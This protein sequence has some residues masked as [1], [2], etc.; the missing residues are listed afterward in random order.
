[1]SAAA[2]RLVYQGSVNAWECDDGGHL[3]VRFHFERA[4][5]GLAHLA[6]ALAMPRAFAQGAGATL[7]PTEA[8]LR[9][10][11]EARAGAPL[12]MHGGVVQLGES[13]ARFLF[14][15]RH[16]DGAPA[17]AITLSARHVDPRQ[18]R[19]FAWSTRTRA[20]A[21][22]LAAKLPDHAK[23]RSID[24]ARAPGEASLAR[25]AK[26]GAQRIGAVLVRP[27]QCDAFGRLRAEFALGFVSDSAPNLLA[28]WRAALAAGADVIPAGAVLE[29]RIAFRR[30]PQAG[31][32]IEVHSAI[33]EIGEKTLRLVHWLIEPESGAAWASLEVVALSFDVKTRK[34]LA[35]SE[36]VREAFKAQVI[37]EMTL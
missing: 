33:S 6:A 23:P 25:A 4:M 8:H 27:D 28:D 24:L 34:A 17:A 11:K 31:D 20:A 14:D 12:V 7:L 15:L 32:L 30:W 21:K 16:G 13:D 3:N 5:T 26:L 37:A 2:P 36:A 19:A 29:A 9:F 35:A 22:A 10:L 1:M 18:L